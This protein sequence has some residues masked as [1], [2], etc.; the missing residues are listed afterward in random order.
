MA[1]SLLIILK[2]TV[3]LM[4]DGLRLELLLEHWNMDFWQHSL[5]VNFIAML[6][7]LRDVMR[8]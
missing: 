6:I 5:G 8:E 2:E 7:S 4:E 3:M 1:G